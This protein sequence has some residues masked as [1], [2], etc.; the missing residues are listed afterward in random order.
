MNR[1]R[2]SHLA[3]IWTVCLPLFWIVAQ[4]VSHPALGVL[5]GVGAALLIWAFSW[6][7]ANRW[8]VLASFVSRPDVADWIIR[9]AINRN[10]YLHI[11]VDGAYM[12]RY[13][14]INRP[15][16]Q[17]KSWFRLPFEVRVHCIRRPDRG[18][19]PHDHPWNWR[20]IILAG[21]YDELVED[22]TN[23][24]GV[25]ATV[26]K[27]ANDSHHIAAVSPGGVWTLFIVGPYRQKWGFHTPTGRIPYD[28]Y[29]ARDE[30]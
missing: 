21:W 13:W 28:Q 2:I 16:T 6:F 26:G 15:I 7:L 5:A 10:V 11:G 30:V 24:R 9:Y 17:Q 29:D 20:T 19:D 23:H 14:L 4:H 3:V 25:G 8:E 12:H 18:R 1:P 27:R 22:D